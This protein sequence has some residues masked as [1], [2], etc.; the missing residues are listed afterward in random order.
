MRDVAFV[1]QR[2]VLECG[3][4]IR[5]HDA[6]QSANLLAR[7]WIALVRHRRR[8]FL[9][10]A[11]IFFGFANLRPLQMANFD[12]NLVKSAGN[13]R[14]SR[15]VECM[16]VALNYL[17]GDRSDLQSE[18]CANFLFQLGSQMRQRSYSPGDFSHA[19]VLG[20]VLE[21]LDIALNLR[22]PVS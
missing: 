18:S 14:Q 21:A 9:L 12:S 8:A 10:F 7:N 19:H 5:S 3:L 1:P 17:A 6:S 2:D 22:I 15:D 13:H 4:G 16:P 20:R 11:E